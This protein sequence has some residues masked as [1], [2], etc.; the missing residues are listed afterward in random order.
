M[1]RR[2]VLQVTVSNRRRGAEVFA[3][4][5]AAELER[6]GLAAPAVALAASSEGNALPVRALGSSPLGVSTLRALRR[7]AVSAWT[8]VAHGSR[9][10][11]ACAAALAATGVPFVY[12]SIGDPRVWSSRGLRRWRTTALL[13]R[14]RLVAVLWPGAADAL[15]AQHAVPADRIRVI[16]N[17][18]PVER[19]PVVGDH[20]RPEARDLLDLPADGPVV[21]YVGSLS[22]EKNVGA[23][24]AAVAGLPGVHLL[25]AG[26]GPDR[27]TLEAQA[28]LSTPGR[29]HFAGTL[30]G[31]LPA[32]AAADAVVLPSRTEGMPGVLVEAGLCGLPV[33]ATAVGAV[34]EIVV[35]GETGVLVAPGDVAALTGALRRVL[36]DDGAMGLAARA[37]CL[38]RFEIRP[39]G[40]AWAELLGELTNGH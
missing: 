8:V 20:G 25:V 15:V 16:P 7:E 38:A 22:D 18:V 12:R 29:V 40:A 35:D 36:A 19:C 26:D 17:G 37:H 6:R 23:A 9:T 21:A 13:R 10:L 33:V 34:A 28:A 3:T 39:V 27:G 24:V 1:G 2:P 5:L 32:L 31:A 30:P 14:P 11:P 4:D